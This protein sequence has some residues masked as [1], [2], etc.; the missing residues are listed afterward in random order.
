[1]HRTEI[2]Q[3]AKYLKGLEEGLDQQGCRGLAALG[4]VTKLHLIIKRLM[5]ATFQTT[6]HEIVNP[7]EV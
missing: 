1:M 6:N 4:Y 7:I 3:I 2:K 5:D